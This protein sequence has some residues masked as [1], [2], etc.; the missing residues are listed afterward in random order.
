MKWLFISLA[1]IL[2]ILCIG[3][4]ELSSNDN[5]NREQRESYEA[6]I[7]LKRKAPYFNL[8]CEHLLDNIHY[9]ETINRNENKYNGVK[10]LSIY[11]SNTRKV[12][13]SEEMKL[14]TLIEKISSR[15][16]LSKD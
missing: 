8:K 11:E 10:V 15:N 4:N 7:R 9:I 12:N 2:L 5:L 14:R 6:C 1:S 16:K 13:K 3:S